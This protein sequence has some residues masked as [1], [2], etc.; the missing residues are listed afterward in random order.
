MLLRLNVNIGNM[1]NMDMVSQ[2]KTLT[3]TCKNPNFQY[4]HLE[5]SQG[6]NSID[7]QNDSKL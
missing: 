7:S 4:L 1:D 6:H 3:A 5:T 2:S